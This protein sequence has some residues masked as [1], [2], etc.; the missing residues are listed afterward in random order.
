MKHFYG[1]IIRINEVDQLASDLFIPFRK[2]SLEIQV[3]KY[4][5][6]TTNFFNFE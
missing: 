3:E 1:M 4:Q 5:T 6:E 2:K